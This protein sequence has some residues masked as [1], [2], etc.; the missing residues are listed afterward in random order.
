MHSSVGRKT[1]YVTEEQVRE[2]LTMHDA[3]E[4]VELA[5]REKAL[6]NAIMPPKLIVPLPNGDIRA[7]PAYLKGINLAG[8]KV[9]NSHPK[10][11]ALGLP[12]V[13][14]ILIVVEPE[15]GF[16]IAL[17]EATHL[18]AMRTAAAGALATKL[19]ARSDSRKVGLIGAG[20][21]ARYQ[22]L[23][24]DAIMEHLEEVHI[25]SLEKE[26]A[27]SLVAEMQGK[28]SAKYFVHDEPSKVVSEADI[29]VTATP[30]CAP[31]VMND[32]VRN[33]AHIN[34]IGADAPGKQELDPALL[35]RAKV[36]LDD[37][38]Q[39]TESGEVNVPLRSGLMSRDEIS[40]E[41][42]DVLVGRL[43]GRTSDSEVTVFSS[44]GLAIQDV[45]TA[46]VVLRRLNVAGL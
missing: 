10:N 45:A 8:V 21:Q 1:V 11:R 31:I 2:A 19:L 4:A 40:G 7:M 20:V 9:V 15:T 42:C 18:T 16:P 39:G 38:A 32:W 13:M 24:L 46:F 3:I 23:A 44:T 29:I 36:F 35:K 30:S 37:W 17:I 22:L 6:G 34:A 27:H 14:A 28:V 25:W 33:G 41:I 12:T 5:F 26:L 43:Q